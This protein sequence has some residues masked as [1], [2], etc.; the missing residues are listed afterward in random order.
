MGFEIRVKSRELHKAKSTNGVIA[1]FKRSFKP[2]LIGIIKSDRVY[3]DE[4]DAAIRHI[5]QNI[6]FAV[7]H[8]KASQKSRKITNSQ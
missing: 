5:C 3:G 4:K 6:S 1:T 8:K 2:Q 7:Y